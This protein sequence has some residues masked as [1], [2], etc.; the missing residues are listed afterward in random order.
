VKRSVSLPVERPGSM[1]IAISKPE[2]WGWAV[3]VCR[4][5][6]EARAVLETRRPGAAHGG[7]GAVG[8]GAQGARVYPVSI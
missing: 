2:G 6:S 5:T 3:R 8:P 1:T 4:N 7:P